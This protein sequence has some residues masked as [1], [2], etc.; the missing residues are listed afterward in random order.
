MAPYSKNTVALMDKIELIKW[1][2][3]VTQKPRR[4]F[5]TQEKKYS[6][7]ALK[8]A[9]EEKIYWDCTILH[10]EEEIELI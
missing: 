8:E 9:F 5:I 1:I 2:E 3:M 7:L 6:A 4:L 10:Y